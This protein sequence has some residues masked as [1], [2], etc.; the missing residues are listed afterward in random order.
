MD[1]VS[2]RQQSQQLP[3]E[4]AVPYSVIGCCEIDKHSILSRKAILNVLCQQDDLVYDRPP[5]SKARLLL[6]DQWVDYWFGTWSYESL[7]DFKGDTQERYGNV[8]RAVEP[9]LKF[10]AQLRPSKI[11]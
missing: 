6:W 11:V 9:Q 7:E 4:A 10:T 3:G 5:W 1:H 2:V 8:G